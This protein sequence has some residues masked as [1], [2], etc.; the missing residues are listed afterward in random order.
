MWKKL[1]IVILGAI[2]A[3]TTAVSMPAHAWS[4]MHYQETFSLKAKCQARGQWLVRSVVG[5]GAYD[6]RYN[7][8]DRKYHLWVLRDDDFGC[9]V[10]PADER[11]GAAPAVTPACGGNV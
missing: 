4:W 2:V 10:P 5:L 7:S 3:L 11:A 6:C 9:G 1:R 8:G